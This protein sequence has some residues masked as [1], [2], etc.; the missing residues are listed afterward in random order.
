M[1]HP[2]ANYMHPIT[3]EVAH[4]PGEGGVAVEHQAAPG[5]RLSAM[6]RIAIYDKVVEML[7]TCLRQNTI[8]AVT[9]KAVLISKPERSEE[10]RVGKE[11]ATLCRSRWSPYH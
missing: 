6:D 5:E 2:L 3:E 8:S 1:E 10:R 7:H 11:C 4:R 9:R